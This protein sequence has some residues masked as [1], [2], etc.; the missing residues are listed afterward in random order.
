MKTPTFWR[1]GVWRRWMI[2][3]LVVVVL[4][5]LQVALWRWVATTSQAVHDQRTAAEQI[6]NLQTYLGQSKPDEQSQALLE[7][8]VKLALVQAGAISQTVDQLEQTA[9]RLGLALTAQNITTGTSNESAGVTSL[10]ITATVSGPVDK[11]L[12]YV[13]SIEHLDHIARIQDFSL[14]AA[15]NGFSLA[16]NVVFAMEVDQHAVSQAQANQSRFPAN[17][18][19]GAANTPSRNLGTD[20]VVGSLLVLGVLVIVKIVQSRRL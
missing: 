12:Q 17:E 3:L 1:D 2:G 18:S 14:T 19:A 5:S 20:L 9:Q 11:L 15:P 7:N 16:F 4:A 6:A 10:T 13:E 8:R